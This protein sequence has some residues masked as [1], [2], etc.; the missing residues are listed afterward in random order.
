MTPM[1]GWPRGYYVMCEALPL[2][3]VVLS[4]LVVTPETLSLRLMGAGTTLRRALAELERVPV[5]PP[6]DA[7]VRPVAQLLAAQKRRRDASATALTPEEEEL[8]RSLPLV[9][10]L[11][12]QGVARGR[13]TTLAR[14]VERRLHRDL[15]TPETE[16]LRSRLAADGDRVLDEVADLDSPALAAWLARNRG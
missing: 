14:V 16:T 12:A 6:R 4:E 13:W 15:G 7:L 5:G 1:R 8:M 3:A 9:D 10:E 11:M 2:S